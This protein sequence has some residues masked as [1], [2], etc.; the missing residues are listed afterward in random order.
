MPTASGTLAAVPGDSRISLTWNAVVGE[1]V[2]GYY[3][4]RGTSAVG[5]YTRLNT[6]A[7]LTSPEYLDIASDKRANVLLSNVHRGH[8]GASVGR[9]KH[10][11]R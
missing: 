11:V 9:L 2:A 10:C 5:P 7:L 3:V 8:G 6:A 4:E 1:D